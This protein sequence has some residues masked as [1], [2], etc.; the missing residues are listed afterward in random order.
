MKCHYPHFTHKQFSDGRVLFTGTLIVKPEFPVYTISIEYRGPLTPLVR[1]LS[2]TLVENCPHFYKKEGALCLYH[3]KD[4]SW[5]TN[6]MIS[7]YIV[8]WTASWIYFYEVWL[9]EGIWYGPEA[10]HDSN[11]TL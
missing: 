4:F 3:P 1:V 7:K 10:S 9:Q 6:T 11:K 8:S 2:P 5:S